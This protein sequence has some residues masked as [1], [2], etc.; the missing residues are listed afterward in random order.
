MDSGPEA[1]SGVFGEL[2]VDGVEI[3]PDGLVKKVGPLLKIGS[4]RFASDIP[5]D[6]P[7]KKTSFG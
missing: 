2:G 7:I 5:E 3:R 4:S 6:L 1:L